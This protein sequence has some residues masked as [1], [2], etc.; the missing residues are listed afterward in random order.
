MLAG[1]AA[2]LLLKAVILQHRKLA[3][4]NSLSLLQD[5]RVLWSH[6]IVMLA[7]EAGCN[8]TSKQI[9]VAWSL[10][11]YVY[12]RGRYP[13]PIEPRSMIPRKGPSGIRVQP[14]AVTLHDTRALLDTFIQ[15][16]RASLTG[17]P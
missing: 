11:E 15:L 3:G 4:T 7:R 2:E 16:A 13:A 1:M 5:L 6:D 9:M 14:T 17:K 12:W 10:T 8:L